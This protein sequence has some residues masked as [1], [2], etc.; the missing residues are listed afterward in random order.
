MSIVSITDYETAR[1]AL[2]N[3]DLKQ[4][5][6]DEGAVLMH[7]VLVALHGDEHQARR[8]L[9]GKVFKRNFLHYYENE[10]FPVILAE[11]L[12]PFLKTG[13][14]D[15]LDFGYRTMIDLTIQFAGID[16][17]D[18]SQEELETL[19]RILRVLGE[20]A[21]LAHYTG[22]KDEVRKRVKT[23][24]DEFEQKFFTH[25]K[26]RREACIAEFKA[27]KLSEDEL[28]RD[29]LTVMLRN[30]DELDLPMDLILRETA[31]MYLA[32]AHTSIHSLTHAM[33][34]IFTWCN[35]H[36]E[37]R[38]K[39][40][41]DPLFLQHC[42]HES[43]RLHPSSPQSWRTATC[44]I[45]IQDKQIEEGTTVHIDLYHADR[46]TGIFGA[47]ADTFNPY[48]QVART[49]PPYGL[50]FGIG[51]HACLGRALAAGNLAKE[52]T[53]PDQHQYGTV[54]L[55]ARALL[56]HGARPDPDNPARKDPNSKRELWDTYPILL[57]SAAA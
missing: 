21:T 2:F 50:A 48:R 57:D 49:H 4:A 23:H 33:H 8:D 30:E 46:D 35:D 40:A 42:V 7:K 3:P 44:P 20:A 32:G 19:L 27:G 43:M 38:N 13:R 31:F 26:T 51:I 12:T 5:L 25:S 10:V 28:P 11:S 47:D 1:Q 34:E 45:K 56:Q 9:E 29:I 18:N 17:V 14:A 41:T 24:L 54:A 16:R 52:D 36:P 15:L 55:L 37:D 6:Y 39:I 53:D 22:D